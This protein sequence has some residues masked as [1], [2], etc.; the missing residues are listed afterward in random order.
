[1][2]ALHLFVVCLLSVLLPAA[3]GATAPQ[4]STPAWFSRIELGGFE[5]PL[6][7]GLKLTAAGQ[8]SHGEKLLPPVPDSGAIFGAA[9]YPTMQ[10][11]LVVRSNAAVSYYATK[12][13]AFSEVD[14]FT[15]TYLARAKLVRFTKVPGLVYVLTVDVRK[16][17]ELGELGRRGVRAQEYPD[18][19]HRVALTKAAQE[20]HGVPVADAKEKLLGGCYKLS[21]KQLNLFLPESKPINIKLPQELAPPFRSGPYDDLAQSVFIFPGNGIVCLTTKGWSLHEM[22]G[23]LRKWFSVEGIQILWWRDP[24]FKGG[25]FFVNAAM[26]ATYQMD[27]ASGKLIKVTKEGR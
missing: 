6:S 16:E 13:E 19:Y 8:L 7:S 27:V 17:E 26:G 20:W 5:L 2:K 12:D 24:S 23:K 9:Y 25:D 10:T 22:N 18:R 15:P 4:I 3:I 21:E 14:N 1:M 11:L